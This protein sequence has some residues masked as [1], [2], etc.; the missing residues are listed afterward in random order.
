M[1]SF[2]PPA[3][4]CKVFLLLAPPSSGSSQQAPP[5]P[6]FVARPTYRLSMRKGVLTR[7][8]VGQAEGQGMQ[9]G[10]QP[11]PVGGAE[12]AE[13]ASSTEAAEPGNQQP[14]QQ[15]QPRWRQ[16]A[17]WFQSRHVLQGLN[18]GPDGAAG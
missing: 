8:M 11:P 14:Q 18:Q 16:P 13:P 1:L 7:V 4:S 5:P 15:E 9:A 17:V 10:G 2:F 3:G 6:G 12:A